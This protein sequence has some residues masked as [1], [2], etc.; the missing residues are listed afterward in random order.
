MSIHIMKLALR[1]W[2]SQAVHA[3][4]MLQM[5]PELKVD[6]T[7]LNHLYRNLCLLGLFRHSENRYVLSDLGLHLKSPAVQTF[8]SE[9]LNDKQWEQLINIGNDNNWNNGARLLETSHLLSETPN[10][11][12]E[13]LL[14]YRYS[15]AL[16]LFSRYKMAD[17]LAGSA[18]NAK[19]LSDKLSIPYEII[20]VILESLLEKNILI[21]N[22][23][24]YALS[25]YGQLLISTNKNTW[26][27]FVL[28]EDDTKWRAS[29]KI[30]QS[31]QMGN[32]AYQLANGMNLYQY[33]EQNKENKFNFDQAMSTVSIYENREILNK[34][35]IGD[36]TVVMDCG[37]GHGQLI[38]VLLEKNSTM[39]GILFEMTSTLAGIAITH[40]L[41]S[42]YS[43]RCRLV[44]GDFFA[45]ETIPHSND[46]ILLKRVLHNWSDE[47][48]IQIL[49]N[50]LEKGKRICILEH[51][52]NESQKLD[53]S[54]AVDLLLWACF[55]SGL[56]DKNQ[57]IALLTRAGYQNISIQDVGN[58]LAIHAGVSKLQLCLRK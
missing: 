24:R 54:V 29:A 13:L 58:M 42:T 36:A 37:G 12:R 14:G 31:I 8:S 6:Q 26:H 32:N 43:S 5:H 30:L 23:G 35:D 7:Q 57:F 9:C 3:A 40:P 2:L 1:Y 18:M 48:T 45:A 10:F 38:E 53:F 51:I 41:R 16:N 39:T 27:H 4:V 47:Q 22:E 11:L 34:L 17:V 25:E 33:L 46:L 15:K 56:R 52:I 50:L 55:G 20:A 21:K 49:R 44:A 28:H 19:E